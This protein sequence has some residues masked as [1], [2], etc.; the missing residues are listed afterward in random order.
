MTD[1]ETPKKVCGNCGSDLLGTTTTFDMRSGG[2][3]EKK[4]C[5]NCDD[6]KEQE[7][8]TV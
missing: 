4:T 6:Y 7:L 2:M 1:K 5:Y 8:K 3:T